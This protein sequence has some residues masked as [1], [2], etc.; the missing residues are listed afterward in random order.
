MTNT[1]EEAQLSPEQKRRLAKERAIRGIPESSDLLD[2]S[3][4]DTPD[5][6]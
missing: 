5:N 3:T 1:T 2:A 4:Y 6:D